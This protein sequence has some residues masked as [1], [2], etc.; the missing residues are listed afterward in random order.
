[1]HGEQHEARAVIRLWTATR[2]ATR[3]FTWTNNI[4]FFLPTHLLLYNTYFIVDVNILIEIWFLNAERGWKV[5]R[6]AEL[7][8]ASNKQSHKGQLIR[9]WPKAEHSVLYS[10]T[11]IHVQ[12]KSTSDCT[13]SFTLVTFVVFLS[14]VIMNCKLALSV[15]NDN[16]D[17]CTVNFLCHVEF[18]IPL[19]HHTGRSFTFPYCCLLA[20]VDLIGW[21]L[22]FIHF[23]LVIFFLTIFN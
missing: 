6:L 10:S 2:T 12:F 5:R 14:E 15:K 21:A 23:C 7:T 19:L 1:M 16:V 17:L 9:L 8:N 22:N 18:S 4:F 11:D 13:E 3:S 20:L